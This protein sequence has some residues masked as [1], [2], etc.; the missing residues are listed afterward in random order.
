[1]KELSGSYIKDD[2]KDIKPIEYSI[3]PLNV[4]DSEVQE[5]NETI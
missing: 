1:M 4:I 5:R 2:I 3:R